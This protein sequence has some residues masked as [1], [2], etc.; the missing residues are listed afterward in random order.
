MQERIGLGFGGGGGEKFKKGKKKRGAPSVKEKASQLA[1]SS[2]LRE[3][4]DQGRKRG[5]GSWMQRKEYR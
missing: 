3:P 4:K 5:K 2:S 1:K